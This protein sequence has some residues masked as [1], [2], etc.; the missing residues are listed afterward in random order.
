MSG[1]PFPNI[2]T[3]NCVLQFLL[4][5]PII[6][7]DNDDFRKLGHFAQNNYVVHDRNTP[8]NWMNALLLPS[9]FKNEITSFEKNLF[10]DILFS[11]MFCMNTKSSV[12]NEFTVPEIAEELFLLDFHLVFY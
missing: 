9:H 7:K 6:N 12:L 11:H 2:E 3:V 4:F 8:T 10:S 5:E 1:S